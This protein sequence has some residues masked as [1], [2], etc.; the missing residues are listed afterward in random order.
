MSSA[1]ADSAIKMKL[2]TLMLE[3]RINDEA[4]QALLSS[5]LGS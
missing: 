5:T 2:L 4:E 3:A 1:A